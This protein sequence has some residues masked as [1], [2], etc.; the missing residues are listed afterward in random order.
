MISLGNFGATAKL[1]VTSTASSYEGVRPWPAYAIHSDRAVH[2]KRAAIDTDD[3]TE[4]DFHLVADGYVRVEIT[5][6][7]FL[8]FVLADGESDGSIYITPAT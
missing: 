6:G 3:A 7:E 8:S 1:A 2:L 4:G 5:P